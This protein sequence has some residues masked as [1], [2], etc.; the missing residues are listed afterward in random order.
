MAFGLKHDPTNPNTYREG[1]ITM[2][3]IISTWPFILIRIYVRAF[4]IKMFG[5]DDYLIV[6]AQIFYTAFCVVTYKEIELVPG[7]LPSSLQIARKNLH[8][9]CPLSL[10]SSKF[11][12]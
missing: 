5:A 1:V 6:A 8:V 3:L 4:M 2:A 11:S 7:A 12:S 9:C 10:S